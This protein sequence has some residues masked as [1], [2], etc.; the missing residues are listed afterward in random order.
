MPRQYVKQIAHWVNNAPPALVSANF[1]TRVTDPLLWSMNRH[2]I[3]AAFGAGVAIAFVPLPIHMIAAVLA[4]LYWRLNL[5]VALGQHLGGEFRFTWCHLLRCVPARDGAAAPGRRA[6][7]PFS[8]AGNGWSTAWARSGSPSCSGASSAQWW[9]P[10]RP[11]DTG[12]VW[13]SAVQRKF[14]LRRAAV[15][16][17][18]APR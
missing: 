17:A 9:P 1:G 15:P 4:A 7:S 11:L 5:P 6:T 2:S 3:T 13:R 10:A 12:V 18:K 14:R 16:A 8:S